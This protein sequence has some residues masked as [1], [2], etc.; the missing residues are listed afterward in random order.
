MFGKI[1]LEHSV[2][3]ISSL[4]HV[5]D[6][7]DVSLSFWRLLSGAKDSISFL[8]MGQEQTELIY[9]CHGKKRR[10]RR[11]NWWI[12]W[13]KMEIIFTA[14]PGLFPRT[15]LD[16]LFLWRDALLFLSYPHGYSTSLDLPFSRSTE[17]CQ[18][19]S[20]SRIFA[21]LILAS[22]QSFC[23]VFL[24]KCSHF[25]IFLMHSQKVTTNT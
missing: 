6:D 20:Y 5:R 12:E 11:R 25:L 17:G 13:W 7:E 8:E 2:L 18:M 16:H 21:A 22:A 3:S 10:Q 9:S 4:Q 19:F 23:P 14:V 1:K 15:Q 24:A